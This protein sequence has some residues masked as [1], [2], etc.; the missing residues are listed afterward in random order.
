MCDVSDTFNVISGLKN[1][2]F[3]SSVQDQVKYAETLRSFSN[4]GQL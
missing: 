2:T 1:Y 4:V 3:H